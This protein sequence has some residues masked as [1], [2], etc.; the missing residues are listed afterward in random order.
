MVKIVPIK[1][2]RSLSIDWPM[3]PSTKPYW[4]ANPLDYLSHVIGHE[5]KNSML[6]EL[7]RQDLASGVFA[8]PK[9]R[10]QRNFSGVGITI[11]LTEKGA[12][13]KEDVIRIIF[14]FI[15]MMKGQEIP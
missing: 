11:T 14:A 12:E 9:L 8:Y 6:S 1:D 13:N 10:C 5:G 15:N 3:M 2:V 4:D 7:I